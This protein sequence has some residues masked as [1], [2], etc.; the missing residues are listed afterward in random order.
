MTTHSTQS[1]QPVSQ[2]TADMAQQHLDVFK[3]RQL[4]GNEGFRH[5]AAYYVLTGQFQF[6]DGAIGSAEGVEQSLDGLSEEQLL[7]VVKNIK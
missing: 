6:V 5:L 4:P 2:I 1:Q 3:S 7:E